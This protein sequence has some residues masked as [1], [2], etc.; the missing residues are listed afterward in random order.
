MQKK[1]RK[2]KFG[3]LVRDK[4]VQGIIAAG[5]KPNFRT[6]MTDEYVE[7]LKKKVLEE[8]EELPKA[9]EN[10]EIIEEIADIEEAINNLLRVMGVQKYKVKKHQSKKNAER[11]SFKRRFYIESVEV[12]S[13]SEWLKY[14]LAH[15]DKYPEIK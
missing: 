15:P 10:K 6:L 7:E 14:Y 5:N 1:I 12:E 3:K 11:G 2:F 13:D 9:K 8:A 4:I